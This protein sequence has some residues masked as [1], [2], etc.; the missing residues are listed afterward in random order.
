MNLL[1][2]LAELSH[3]F[4]SCRYV[5]GGGGNTSVK[6]AETLWIKPS[7]AALA[8]VNPSFFIALDRKKLAGIYTLQPPADDAKSEALVR[9]VMLS[10]VRPGSSGIPSI[11]SPTHNIF[12]ARYIV[13]THP[14]LVNGMTCSVGGAKICRRLFPD[15]LWLEYAEPGY[16]L[17]M[18]IRKE[19]K[20]YLASHDTEPS[21]V[22]LQNHGLIVAADLPE[23]IRA[24]SKI[25]FERLAREYDKA[26]VSTQLEIGAKPSKD[27]TESAESLIRSSFKGIEPLFIKSSGPFSLVDGPVS[28]E[29][30]VYTG[31]YYLTE[32]P[33]KNAVTEFRACRGYPIRIIAWDNGVFGVGVSEKSAALALESAQDASLIKQLAQAFG[34]I[35]YMTDA[36]AAKIHGY[37]FS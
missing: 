25:V 14:A 23:Q 36:E 8:S 12:K 19:I 15:A 29:H 31:A 34:G 37:N 17:C 20:N 13:H 22:F 26:G 18:S 3:D 6:D 27:K 33:T 11:E 30:L 1:T 10:A 4:G 9:Q 28:L 35:R 5:R 7:G 21:I 32:R 16:A 24:I 2:I